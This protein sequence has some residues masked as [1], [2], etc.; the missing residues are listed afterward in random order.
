MRDCC[1]CMLKEN[2]SKVLLDFFPR[3]AGWREIVIDSDRLLNVKLKAT[4]MAC[5][6]IQLLALDVSWSLPRV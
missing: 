4:P 5:A 3:V 1:H 6:E 2:S